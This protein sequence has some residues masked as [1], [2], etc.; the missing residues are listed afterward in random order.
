MDKKVLVAYASKYGATAE[1]A[2]KIGEI[3]KEAG[4][5]ADVTP[6]K[7]VK[8][9]SPYGAVV[10][11]TAAYMFRW[12]KEATKFLKNN[13]KALASL[14]VWL[15]MSGPVGEGDPVKLLEGHVVPK[16]IKPVI[17]RIGPVDLAVFHGV[18]KF[19]K[20]NAFER[21][22]MKNMK[23]PEGDFR[24]WEAIEAWAKG[25]AGKIKG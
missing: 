24:D 13:E 22:V 6:V 5:E 10:L 8:D 21:W 15:F 19:E 7:E 17:D 23:S 1:I 18:I 14:P 3:L 25:I 12:R 2:D 9:I 16:G 4:V 20:M 11:G